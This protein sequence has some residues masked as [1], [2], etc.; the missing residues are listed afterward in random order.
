LAHKTQVFVATS[1]DHF[2]S[3]LTHTLEVSQ[4][5][6]T[7]ARGFSLNEDLAEAISLGHDLGH[8]PFGHTGEKVLN[9]L[10]PGGFNHQDQSVRVVTK[11]A[12]NGSGLNLSTEVIDGIGKHSK[13]GGPVFIKGPKCPLTPE[14]ELVRASD[15]IA[16]LAHDLEDALESNL[17]TVS[18]IPLKIRSI[19][20]PSAFD[21]VKVMVQD[22][23][24]NSQLTQNGYEFSFSPA[25]HEAMT[26]L[27]VFLSQEVYRNPNLVNQLQFCVECLK[28]IFKSL[29]HNQKLFDGLPNRHLAD[30]PFQAIRD[31]IAGMTDRYAISYAQSISKSSPFARPKDLEFDDYPSVF[32]Y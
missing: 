14:G 13:G 27:R 5:A 20:G 2:R 11:L 18:D 16:Y 6:R 4:V 1:S 17:L 7:L 22:L 23:I 26:L 12:N 24:A 3:R 25:M 32:D 10:I 9:R 29:T 15:L 8:T 31:F 19:F 21:R 30:D 28:Y